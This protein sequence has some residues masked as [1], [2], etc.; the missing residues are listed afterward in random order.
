[1]K[2]SILI[3]DL[4]NIL[5]KNGDCDVFIWNNDLC[6]HI[7]PQYTKYVYGDMLKEELV[8]IPEYKEDFDRI[9]H[10]VIIE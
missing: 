2:L 3:K 5:I 8:D 7:E 4:N 9:L 6:E 10:N 1:M